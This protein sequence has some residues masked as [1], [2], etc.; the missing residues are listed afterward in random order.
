[1]TIHNVD[2][3]QSLWEDIL[4]EIKKVDLNHIPKKLN[5][6]MPILK[7][8]VA[9]FCKTRVQLLAELYSCVAHP[10]DHSSSM[11]T[12]RIYHESRA[13]GHTPILLKSVQKTLLKCTELISDCHIINM[14]RA[15]EVLVFLVADLDRTYKPTIP[16][17]LPIAFA[18]KGYN[19]KTETMRKMLQDELR[20]LFVRGL[21]VPVISYDGQWAKLAFRDEDGDPL[22]MLELQKCVSNEIQK[23]NI[24]DICDMIF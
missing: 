17:A 5:S 23:R 4:E 20:E 9:D 2:M 10:C 3:D 1:M 8:R 16:H 13:N 18:L 11:D 12:G 24:K 7:S 19:M 22:T 21:Y 6:S 14:Q 15:S